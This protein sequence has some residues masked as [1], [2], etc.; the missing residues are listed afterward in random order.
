MSIRAQTEMNLVHSTVHLFIR[1]PVTAVWAVLDSLM[2]CDQQAVSTRSVSVHSGDYARRNLHLICKYDK[3]QLPK[4]G[5]F[6]A[7]LNNDT[8]LIGRT[9]LSLGSGES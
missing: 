8:T 6:P 9:I 3:A 5:I 7:C 2:H 4:C 1:P